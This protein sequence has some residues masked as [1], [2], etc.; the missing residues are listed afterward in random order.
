METPK[1][2]GRHGD[3]GLKIG[4]EGMQPI[5]DFID[6]AMKEDKPFLIWYAPFLPHTPHNPPE[7]LLKKY[8]K[9]GR[10]KDV[11][12]YYAMCEWFDQTCGELT[13]AIDQRNL[14]DNT[15]FIYI[16]DNGWVAK[17]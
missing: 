15:I 14:R 5:H 10:E 11:A 12:K 13:E 3:K 6:L 8:T 2:G 17:S 7:H 4:R 9:E 16:C 1:K